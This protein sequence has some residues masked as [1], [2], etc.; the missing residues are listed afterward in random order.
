MMK[1]LTA[2]ILTLALAF[3][4]GLPTVWANSED[5]AQVDPIAVVQQ[6]TADESVESA[7][8]SVLERDAAGIVQLRN[9]LNQLQKE[10]AE[11]RRIIGDLKVKSETVSAL[12]AEAKENGELKKLEKARDVEKDIHM[13]MNQ[14]DKIRTH[15]EGLWANFHQE[16]KAGHLNKAEQILQNIVQDKS[17]I[18]TLLRGVE[19]LV[20]AE[21]LVLK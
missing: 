20:N 5:T 7:E 1:K 11:H 3:G 8:L 2:S 19:K 14:V 13:L 17:A 18:N 15:K 21:I 16:F 6:I 10:R 9:E 4:T 12:K